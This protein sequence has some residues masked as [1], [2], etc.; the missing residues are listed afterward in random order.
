MELIKRILKKYSFD[1]IIESGYCTNYITVLL[2]SLFYKHSCIDNILNNNHENIQNIYLQE[3]IKSKFIEYIRKGYSIQM[4][5]LIE[6]QTFAHI[7]G[8][9]SS[10]SL[11]NE[12][13]I[14]DFYEFLLEISA[15]EKPKTNSYYINIKINGTEC[16]K[17]NDLLETMQSNILLNISVLLAIKLN[18]DASN[19]EIDIPKKIMLYN[20]TIWAIHT[21][22]C[23]DS[24]GSIYSIIYDADSWYIFN[25]NNN[26]N[27]NYSISSI[28]I[29]EIA[30]KIKKECYFII[31]KAN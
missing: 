8:W 22:I 21:I 25:N 29:K 20:D 5:T 26:N 19:C 6:I 4:Q 15:V 3:I 12:H 7:C 31:Y 18:R 28:N 13:N 2:A 16:L 14:E 9:Q 11:L 30:T 10:E 1:F 23:R 17:L 24:N 27:N